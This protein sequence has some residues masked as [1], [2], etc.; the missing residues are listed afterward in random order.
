MNI[1]SRQA[2]THLRSGDVPAIQI[3]GRGVRRVEAPELE[4]DIQRQ[5]EAVRDRVPT[6]DLITYR[7]GFF[8]LSARI[9]SSRT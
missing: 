8:M 3:G 1:S 4:A 9:V 6:G 7:A 2:H 5:Y